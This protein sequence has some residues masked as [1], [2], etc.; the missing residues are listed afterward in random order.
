MGRVE[1][2]R[3]GVLKPGGIRL[4][5]LRRL[6]KWLGWVALTEL[7]LEP[8]KSPGTLWGAVVFEGRREVSVC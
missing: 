5:L 6:L 3:A 1:C 8:L 4:S 2:R 7:L